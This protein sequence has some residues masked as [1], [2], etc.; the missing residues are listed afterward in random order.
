MSRYSSALAIPLIIGLPF[1]IKPTGIVGM[2][3]IVAGLFCLAGVLLLSLASAL[4]GCV[5]ALIDLAI[6]LWWTAPSI[7][8]FGAVAFGLALLFLL[9]IVH[10]ASRFRGAEIDRSAWRAQMA[11]W[12]G[13]AAISVG[14]AVVVVLVASLLTWVLPSFGRPIFAGA[15]AL[16]AFIAAMFR[17][18]AEK[19]SAP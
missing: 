16:A 18:F 15:G 6:A 7:S 5:F 10:F 13:R 4:I 1:W 12:I 11:W 9:E 14:A 3:A 8:V 19:A 2:I 17:S